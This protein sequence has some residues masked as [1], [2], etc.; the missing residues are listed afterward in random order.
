MTTGDRPPGAPPGGDGT[1]RR[2]RGNMEKI[3]AWCRKVQLPDGTWRPGRRASDATM[4]THG[5]CP[6][7]SKRSDM[8]ET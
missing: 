8:N 2:I 7:C 6:D 5:I 1:E 3:C 4:P